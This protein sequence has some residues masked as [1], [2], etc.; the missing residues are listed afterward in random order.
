[1]IKFIH[2]TLIFSPPILS[3][4]VWLKLFNSFQGSGVPSRKKDDNAD[5]KTK[6]L[7]WDQDDA[8]D[9]LIFSRSHL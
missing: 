7:V 8:D 4:Q 6:A 9:I 1:M 5:S 2:K 3:L